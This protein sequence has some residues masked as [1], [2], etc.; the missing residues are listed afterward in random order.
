MWH[1][2][3]DIFALIIFV[4]MLVKRLRMEGRDDQRQ[5]VLIA[6]LVVSILSCV[7]DFVSSTA[8]NLD[9]N[10][11]LYTVSL[12]AY[13]AL[14]PTVAAAWV[15]YMIVL[16]T[17]EDSD[18]LQ[19]RI[20]IAML[21]VVC[22]M[23]IALTN[24]F[25]G[26]FFTLTQGM[27]YARGPLFWPLAVG[28]YSLYSAACLVVMIINRRKITPQSNVL[29]LSTFFFFSIFVP[30]LQSLLPGCLI[31]EISYA[32]LYILCDATVEEERRNQLVL[33]IQEQNEM[34]TETA[35][36]ARAASEAKSEFLSRMSHD[37]RTPLNG[38]IGMTYLTQK[39][40]LPAE[41]QS[42]LEKINTSSK[43]LLSL[44][45]DIL[46]MSKME[47]RAIELHPEPYPYEEFCTYLD[48][49]IRPLCD[50]KRQTFV[51]DTHPI[52]GYT[53]V[54]DITRL[55]RIYFNLLS[56]AVKYTAEGGQIVLKIQEEWITEDSIRFT[57]TVKDNGIG[58]SSEFQDHLFEPFMQ[59]SRN[60]NSEM[61]GSGLGLAIVKKTVEA[62]DGTIAVDSQI[63]KG[64]CF[65]VSMVSPCIKRN[66]AEDGPP[67]AVVTEAS[68]DNR[69]SGIHVLLCEDHLLNQEIAKAL[70]AE[71]GVLV[72]LADDGQK[73]VEVFAKSPIG[74]YQ[75]ILMDL[76]MP[77]MDGLTAS[78]AIRAMAREDARQVPIIAMTADAFSDD[79]KRCAEAG[80]NGH[81]AKPID[82]EALYQSLLA[83]ISD[84]QISNS[85]S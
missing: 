50:E 47:S 70:L 57:I 48:A 21:P 22:Y 33:H 84:R 63:G 80:M 78:R 68:N 39:M 1:T 45:N 2:E 7:V 64:T 62:M 55:N 27:E 29:F 14:M 38:I 24:P 23:L 3:T 37:I 82:P 6:V 77:V 76:R 8:M 71:K 9:D 13:Y 83:E 17:P 36:A 11:V 59:E 19:M 35:K 46:D 40:E 26:W 65:T 18:R 81:V 67:A 73:G 44:V 28:F 53:P 30:L 54:V 72:Q 16:I 25:N 10:W 69:L 31:A 60:D 41:A 61:R 34:L 51:L 15:I 49:V 58:M 43:F 12:T 20:K 32:T 5:K 42:N 79:V 56:N 74:F 85:K 66:D 4:I 52:G 75:A